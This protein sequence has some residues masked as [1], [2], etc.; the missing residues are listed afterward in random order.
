MFR[1]QS[2]FLILFGTMALL[3]SCYYDNEE[4]LYPAPEG[5]VLACDTTDVSYSG[6]VQPLLGEHCTGC[7]AGTTPS[8]NVSLDNHESVKRWADDGTLYGA[9]AHLDGYSQMPKG[10]N[11]LPQ[12]DLDKVKAWI[13]A[14]AQ[15]N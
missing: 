9:M 4:E 3:S 13:D 11:R 8:G 15:N 7:H 12:C 14:G 2:I 6:F 1:L 5:Q 10:G